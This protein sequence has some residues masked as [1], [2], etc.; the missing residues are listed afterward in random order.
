MQLHPAHLV[1]AVLVAVS[2]ATSVGAAGAPTPVA[3]Q[4]VS[5]FVAYQTCQA[6][7]WEWTAENASEGTAVGSFRHHY[8][9]KDVWRVKGGW[10]VQVG[11]T[12]GERATATNGV[13]DC[14]IGGTN[15]QPKLVSYTFPR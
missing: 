9:A 6:R 3:D 8:R 15:A 5:R 10:H 13:A 11:G 2:A 12:R 7:M 4:H 14:V 1:A